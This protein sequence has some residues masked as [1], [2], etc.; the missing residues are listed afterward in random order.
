MYDPEVI[1]RLKTAGLDFQRHDDIGIEPSDFAELMITSG[2]VL[3][4][5]VKYI[6]FHRYPPLLRE[7]APFNN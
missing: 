5:D 1:D 2:L 3:S 6:S 7:T 4:R